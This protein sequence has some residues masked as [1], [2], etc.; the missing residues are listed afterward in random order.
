MGKIY[1]CRKIK[2]YLFLGLHKGHPSYKRSLQLSKEN[3]QHFKNM[4]FINFFLLMW[5]IFALLDPDPDSE[6]GSGSTDLIESRSNPDTDPKPWE[7]P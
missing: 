7:Y 4:K 6:C 3:I 2:F 5:V 1:S